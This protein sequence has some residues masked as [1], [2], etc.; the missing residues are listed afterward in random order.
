MKFEEQNP[1]RRYRVGVGGAI[2]IKD[3][4]RVRLEPNE[5]VTFLTSDGREHDFCAKSWGFYATPSVNGRLRSQG[6]RAALVENPEG[7]RYVMVVIETRMADFL[8]YLK[9]ERQKLLRWL[10]EG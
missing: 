2:E 6:L 9:S 5:Q 8:D 1:P 4:G 3:C 7:R 10:D